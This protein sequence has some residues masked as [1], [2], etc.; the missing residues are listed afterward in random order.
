MS[1]SQECPACGALADESAKFC[2]E[3]GT[4]FGDLTNLVGRTLG[5]KYEI[6]ER[7]GE[8]SMGQIYLA[9]HIGLEKR[10]AIKVLHRDV[11]LGLEAS[12]RFR[13]EGVAAGQIRHRNAIEVFDFDTTEDGL[14]FLAMEFV[15]GRDLRQVLDEDGALSFED[16]S[17]IIL[18]VLAAL[19]AAHSLGIVHRDLKP[20]NIMLADDSERLKV[21]VLDFGLSKLVHRKI[22]ASLT[23]IPGRIIGTPLYMAPEQSSGEEADARADLYAIGLIFYELLVG[24]RPYTGKTLTELLYAQATEPVP[25]ISENCDDP[26][27]PDHLDDF[28]QR[29]LHRD[30]EER[31]QS[32][33]GMV[34]A[35]IGEAAVEAPVDDRRRTSAPRRRGRSEPEKGGLPKIALAGAAVV[36]AIAVYVVISMTGGGEDPSTPGAPGNGAPTS[37]SS[38]AAAPAPA[39]EGPPA[40]RLRERPADARPDGASA[41]LSKL[42]EAKLQLASGD[43]AGAERAA[44]AAFL[45][46]LRDPEAFFVRGLVLRAKGDLDG[47]RADLETAVGDDEEFHG[48]RT[49][50]GWTE[51]EAGDAAAARATFDAVPEGSEGY[52]DA[53]AGVGRIA[54]GEGD[55]AGATTAFDAAISASRECWRAHAGKGDV[56][57]AGG[58]V[59]A[60]V[61]AFEEAR[62]WGPNQIGVL[63]ALGAALLVDGEF[64]AASDEF[65]AALEID[66]EDVAALRG[67]AAAC[68]RDGRSGDAADALETLARVA[69]G[70]RAVALLGLS[71][72]YDGQM[73][74]ELLFTLGEIDRADPDRA[75][76][77]ELRAGLQNIASAHEDALASA[78]RALRVDDQRAGAHHQ[79]GVALFGLGRYEDAAK[80]LRKAVDLDDS[81]AESYLL[82]GVLGL[83]FLVDGS[84]AQEDLKRYVEEAEEPLPEA[85]DWL[86]ELMD[87]GR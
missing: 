6:Q 50:L 64:G 79:R 47:A 68:V 37:T 21:K 65:A 41:Y 60:A 55:T 85:E 16:A 18:Q 32:A 11:E 70:D 63:T 62:R 40:A 24:E 72:A 87:S 54:L 35:L 17:A 75:L 56:A 44:N 19:Q 78:E 82:L 38:T 77:L 30:R 28:F 39:Q 61:E 7:I 43:V 3:C 15:E 1:M 66:S 5:G 25:Y 52:A 4:P 84:N 83:D 22:E 29:A 36:L 45:S 69:S 9:M 42:D 49:E 48:A 14:T 80:A 31:F 86:V 76:K 59:S 46:P 8:G 2:P 27:L 81:M 74:E 53:R 33:Q 58:D 20:A 23:T 26:D 57:L 12:Q 73:E 13:R 67:Y 51:L 71:A 34:A 10:V